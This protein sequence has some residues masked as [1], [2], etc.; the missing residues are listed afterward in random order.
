MRMPFKIVKSLALFFLILGP[1]FIPPAKAFQPS[2]E[3]P[4]SDYERMTLEVCRSV[5]KMF[6]ANPSAVWPGYNLAEQTFLVYIPKKWVLLFNP[7]ERIDGFAV[8]PEGWPELGTK[9]LYREGSY[10]DLIGQLAF[11]FEI[12]GVKTVAIGLPED[13]EDMPTPTDVYLAGFIVHE[14]FH[15][16]QAG[17]FGEIPW[18]REERYPILDRHNTALA[19]LEMRLLMDAVSRSETGARRDVEDLLRMFAAVR[20]ERWRAGEAFVAEFEQGLEIREGTARY[21]EMKAISLIKNTTGLPGFA[22]LSVPGRLEEDFLARFAGDTVSPEDM[23]R[24]RLYP[25]GAALGYLCDF[26]GLEW[27]SSAQAAGPE[28]AFHQ[29]LFRRPDAAETPAAELVARARKTYGYEQIMKATGKLI[30]EYREGFS[31]EFESF[32]RQPLEKLELEFSYR[33]ISRSRNSLAKTWLVDD[34][35]KSLCRRYRVYTLKNADLSLQVQEAG[36]YEENDW[37]AKHKKVV[38]YVPSIESIALDGAMVK[39]VEGPTRPFRTLEIKGPSMRLTVTKP[40]T[41]TRNERVIIIKIAE[42]VG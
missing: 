39:P 11:D 17:H 19:C 10:G 41:I 22:S 12:G 3:A 27:K 36:V 38:F 2:P 25:V 21:A 7:P 37:E 28:F 15:Q 8:C 30:D 42:T 35:S 4:L 1:G 13:P 6:R 24:N 32:N 40:G 23:P 18:Q 31:R 5:V 20:A 34:G 16:F 33:G 9:V 26:L 14:A 29:V